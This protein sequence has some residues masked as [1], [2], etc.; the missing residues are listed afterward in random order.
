MSAK[1]ASAIV[2][3]AVGAGALALIA[4]PLRRSLHAI[5]AVRSCEPGL[6]WPWLWVGLGAA[7]CLLVAG[8]VRGLAAGER[9]GLRRYAGLIGIALL[10]MAARRTLDGPP[11]PSPSEGLQRAAQFVQRA[12][13]AAHA[14]DRR[15]P[16]NEA[17]LGHDL[18]SALLDLGFRR[19]GAIAQA[20]RIVVAPGAG[21][22]STDPTGR[23]PGEIVLATDPGGHR[24]WITAFTLDGTG[25]VTPLID[26]SGHPFVA[27]SVDGLA[28]DRADPA[29]PEY[30]LTR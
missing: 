24:C 22:A 29:F 18:P 3:T 9:A 25:S 15:Y 19:R 23:E 11:R 20:T 1:F 17:A 13:D 7:A 30:P 14:R 27:T 6:V 8:V 12:A 26:D 10:C 16:Q 4:R 5:T 21:A 2:Y 28:R